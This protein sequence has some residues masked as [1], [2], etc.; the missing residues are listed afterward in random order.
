VNSK[1]LKSI[2]EIATAV[3]IAHNLV[4]IGRKGG[5]TNVTVPCKTYERHI[6]G[7]DHIEMTMRAE[8]EVLQVLQLLYIAAFLAI[9]LIQFLREFFGLQ[10][11]LA[12]TL[13]T[14]SALP[15]IV[16]YLRSIE[17]KGKLERGLSVR[18]LMP[19][20]V[21]IAAF[22][23]LMRTVSDIV[24]LFGYSWELAVSL[25]WFIISIVFIILDVKIYRKSPQFYY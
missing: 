17:R 6:K 22:F 8:S 12:G 23:I 14:I 3:A 24:H 7:V 20:L 9:Q 11:A 5:N 15:S 21:S 4:R 19:G 2:E 16:H 18:H 25:L 13:M 10:V 1:K